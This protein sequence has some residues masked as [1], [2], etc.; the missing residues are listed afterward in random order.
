MSDALAPAITLHE[1]TPEDAALF[2]RLMLA[3]YEE[4]RDWLVPASGAFTESLE[5]VRQAIVEG[6]AVIVRL[7]G[8][9][10]ACGRFEW[11][12]DRSFIEV[13]RLSVLPA[14]R[15]R[16]LAVRMLAWFEAR[17]ATLGVPTVVLGVRLALPRNI[18]LYERAGYEV[19]DYE[20][21][22]DYGRVS[23]WMRKNV[24]ERRV[25]RDA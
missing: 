2:Q 15:G 22:P 21:R 13:G 16:G 1:A 18:A 9:P 19:Y 20:D 25:E 5:D 10:V 6:G 12:P 23:V 17:A 7:D 3:A 24:G 4:Y 11:A 14:Y 8:E